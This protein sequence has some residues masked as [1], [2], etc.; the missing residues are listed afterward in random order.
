MIKAIKI[1]F[2]KAPNLPPVDIVTTPVTVFVGPNNSGKSK[3]LS[4]IHY[5]CTSGQLNSMD[6]IL[7]EIE[8]DSFTLDL[9]KEKV[10]RITLKPHFNEALMPD[11]IIVGK[12]GSRQQVREGQLLDA[13]QNANSQIHLFCQWYL[14]FN[15]LILDGR[16]R[17]NLVNQQSA[18]DL[19]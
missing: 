5:R 3:I 11:H 1:K 7:S 15:T 16:S 12:G 18:G 14:A 8:F 6:V 17:I 10:S 19:Q 9:A 2:G 13:L 4:E